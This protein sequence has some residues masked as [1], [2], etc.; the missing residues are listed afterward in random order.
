MKYIER[1]LPSLGETGVVMVS[2]GR[3]MPGIRAVPETDP[4]VA[5]IKGRLDMADVVA[6]AVAN[7]QR[8]PAEP[9]TSSRG[10]AA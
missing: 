3:L 1:V 10:H 6:N 7:R 4:A 8:L 2:L 9:R 5:A